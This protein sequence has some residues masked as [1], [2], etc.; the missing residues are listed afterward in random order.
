MKRS[1]Y[2]IFSGVFF[3][4]IILI[5]TLITR[6]FLISYI[7]NDANGLISLFTSIIGLICITELGVGIAITYSMYKPITENDTEKIAILYHFFNK[8]YKKIALI[9]TI[10]GICFIPLLQFF[11]NDYN[12]DFNYYIIFIIQLA[13]VLLTYLF[14]AEITLINAHKENYLTTTIQSSTQ[15]LKLILQCIVLVIWSNLYLYSFVV[16]I[17]ELINFVVMKVIVSKKYS[18]IC[19][20]KKSVLDKETK[21]EVIKN[22]KAIF[23]HKIGGVLVNTIDSIIISTALGVAILGYYSNY[24][25]LV[26]ALVSICSM[27]FSQMVSTIG[28]IFAKKNMIEIKTYFKRFYYVNY[29]LASVMFFCFFVASDSF[30]RLVFGESLILAREITL[31]IAINHFIQFMRMTVSTFKDSS[32]LYY[33]DRYKPLFEGVL[34]L[35]LSLIFINKL[36]VVGVILSTIITNIF[37]CHFVEPRILYKY[38]FKESVKK[39][40]ITNYSLIFLFIIIL[41]VYYFN[42]GIYIE[43]AFLEFIANGFIGVALSIPAIVLCLFKYLK[44]NVK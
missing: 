14:T 9:I 12:L 34:N 2:N 42:F 32:G 3:K 6:M 11:V 43:N 36:G 22:V 27:V 37:I 1:F 21:T 28:Q 40:Y 17:S 31:V 39:F 26:T 15:I 29:A 5:I 8:M 4:V 24:L 16:I 13:G 41:S 19:N 10:I 7:G 23:M 18:D 30:I 25:L 35:I 33:Y 44:S 20:I 38:G